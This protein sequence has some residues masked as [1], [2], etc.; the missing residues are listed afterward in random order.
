LFDDSQTGGCFSFN[1][2]TAPFFHK[3]AFGLGKAHL[4]SKAV[5]VE[6]FVEV[7]ET[8]EVADGGKHALA[9][10]ISRKFIRLQDDS[11]DPFTR[12]A[13]SSVRAGWASANH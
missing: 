8:K 11:I 9:H 13:R 10:M 1:L 5:L 6:F 7:D 4:A 2:K 3:E 12:Q